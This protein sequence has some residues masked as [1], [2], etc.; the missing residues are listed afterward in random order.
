MFEP[1]I[2][3]AQMALGAIAYSLYA[4]LYGICIWTLLSRRKSH[5]LWHICMTT[6]LYISVTAFFMFTIAALFVVKFQD[7]VK[8]TSA[9]EVFMVISHVQADIILIHRCF[10]IWERKKTVIILPLLTLVA[11][12]ALG[13]TV[14]LRF[15]FTYS[16]FLIGIRGIWIRNEPLILG[17][18]CSSFLTNI[19][20]T[21]TMAYRL[22]RLAQFVGGRLASGYKVVFALIIESGIAYSFI[23]LL[24]LCS[25]IPLMIKD[26]L[27]WED[28]HNGFVY[29]LVLASGIT[30]TLL[31]VR[32]AMGTSISD[33][34][35]SVLP[36]QDREAGQDSEIP[37]LQSA[38]L[39]VEVNTHYRS[40]CSNNELPVLDISP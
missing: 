1:P 14:A 13:L 25:F 9:C 36:P 17:F 3:I 24:V 16:A 6:L 20:V 23:I 8:V 27:S 11:T 7:D 33:I 26:T 29:V 39:C 21:G 37:G 12:F 4:G 28:I 32:V 18:Y 40:N 31:L 34:Q 19:I 15:G 5:Y 10:M 22:N 35:N 38:G 2:V 30:P